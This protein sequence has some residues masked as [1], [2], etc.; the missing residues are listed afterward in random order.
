[1]ARKKCPKG[2]R[3]VRGICRIRVTLSDKKGK[4]R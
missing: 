2:S 4:G 1:M 3:R